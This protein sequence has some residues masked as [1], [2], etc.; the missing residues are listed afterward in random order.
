MQ[1]EKNVIANSISGCTPPILREEY[2]KNNYF[3]NN[4]KNEGLSTI[5][6]NRS[7]QAKINLR[8]QCTDTLNSADENS[9]IRSGIHVNK[10]SDFLIKNNSYKSKN[11]DEIKIV[12]E[13]TEKATNP[14]RKGG[15]IDFSHIP[16]KNI[17][18]L[19]LKEKQDEQNSSIEEKNNELDPEK[20]M[21]HNNIHFETQVIPNNELKLKNNIPPSKS[22]RKKVKTMFPIL[23]F[24][25]IFSRI[26]EFI[27]SKKQFKKLV[28][29]VKNIPNLYKKIKSELPI[30][31]KI[32]IIRKFKELMRKIRDIKSDESQTKIQKQYQYQFNIENLVS[33]IKRT[34]HPN[35]IE[36]LKRYTKIIFC[37]NKIKTI[38][39][40]KSVRLY[41]NRLKALAYLFKIIDFKIKFEKK[42]L[43]LKYFN[44]MKKFSFFQNYNNVIF[45]L[46]FR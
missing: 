31:K 43:P 16:A 35:P 9:T 24:S 25:K 19:N 40:K 44:I 29:I 20:P 1:L 12:E 21:E 46:I 45:Y 39:L 17:N 23:K 36:M 5:E 7:L 22:V 4:S 32:K 15:R 41:F 3:N 34:C 13:E 18:H 2:H 38:I 30:L 33:K 37:Q 11:H 10:M 14:S 28:V 6:F 27:K 42:N 26:K 8:T